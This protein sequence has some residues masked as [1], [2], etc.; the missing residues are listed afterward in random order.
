MLLCDDILRVKRFRLIGDDG[1]RGTG[2]ST[3]AR[4]SL[5]VF[6]RF[7]YVQTL[8]FLIQYGKWLESL[9]FLHLCLEPILN[10]VLSVIF[11]VLVDVVEVPALS[12]LDGSTE[13]ERSRPM[14][15]AYL[16]S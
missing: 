3:G 10:F 14:L 8:E 13:E 4:E 6:V 12:L 2:R 5:L 16:F 1:L 7:E 15:V 9:R 11:E